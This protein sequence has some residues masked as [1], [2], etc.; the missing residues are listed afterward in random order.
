MQP[1]G[2]HPGGLW[3]EMVPRR[4]ATRLRRERQP[5]LRMGYRV[6]IAEGEVSAAH[7]RGK[8]NRLVPL[9]EGLAGY[10]R[11]DSGQNNQILEHGD[12]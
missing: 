11:R 4:Q 1:A 8:G 3:S 2:A 7:C 12:Q 6:V 10:R 5:G 9:A